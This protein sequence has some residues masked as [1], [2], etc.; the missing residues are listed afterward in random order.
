MRRELGGGQPWLWVT[1]PGVQTCQWLS[2]ML[3]GGT[4]SY[5]SSG[6]GRHW[7][8]S[9]FL[10]F[11]QS[12]LPC[13]FGPS[14]AI[15]QE[16]HGFCSKT[17]VSWS[18]CQH[19]SQLIANS[20]TERILDPFMFW[21]LYQS[22]DGTSGSPYKK[23]ETKIRNRDA[24]AAG[25]CSSIWRLLNTC[26]AGQ[27]SSTRQLWALGW[28]RRKA[29]SFL[30]LLMALRDVFITIYSGQYGR[31]SRDLSL[32]GFWQG[33]ETEDHAWLIFSW[34]KLLVE[35]KSWGL[36]IRGARGSSTAP[37]GGD[38]GVFAQHSATWT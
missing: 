18:G 27:G 21:D 10:A 31:K 33:T 3:A 24:W 22:L 38:W 4:V 6:S 34:G 29:A 26:T 23:A 2:M 12:C 32:F 19:H 16:Q 13:W 1:S 9:S 28:W 15:H 37:F 8:W 14:W 25:R 11:T 17:A 20:E 36:A 35:E 7:G 5:L 30:C